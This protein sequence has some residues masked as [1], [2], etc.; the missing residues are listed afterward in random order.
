MQVKKILSNSVYNLIGQG[1]PIL[2]AVYTLPILISSMGHERLGILFIIWLFIG[3]FSIFDFG[4]GRAL[5]KLIAEKN[6]KNEQD[7]VPGLIFTSL[8]LMLG[9]GLFGGLLLIILSFFLPSMVLKVPENLRQETEHSL[10][11]VGLCIPFITM[12]AG[13]K[14]VLEANHK[15]LGLNVIRFILGVTT[16]LL[17]LFLYYKYESITV[18]VVGLVLARILSWLGQAFLCNRLYPLAFK[19]I[20][21]Q[22]KY[23]KELISFGGWMTAANLFAPIL[24]YTDK[25]FLGSIISVASVTYYSVPYDM[26]TKLLIIP[27]AL[28]ATLLP[29]FTNLIT[30]SKR[31]A[32]LQ[33]SKIIIYTAIV[34]FPICFTLIVFSKEILMYWIDEDFSKHSAMVFQIIILAIFINSLTQI[35][36]VYMQAKGRVD[37]TAKILFVEILIYIPVLVFLTKSYGVIGTAVSFLFRVALDMILFYSALIY[38]DNTVNIRKNVIYIS[39]LFSFLTL[40]LVF[41]GNSHEYIYAMAVF[42]LYISFFHENLFSL[43]K[44]IK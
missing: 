26:G 11:I 44:A 9:L 17:P 35:V 20:K 19:N 25:F 29:L 28:L 27:G 3:Y 23:N 10:F 43:F 34:M 30:S 15:F 7:D 21:Y 37:V 31:E 13:F 2:V 14:G 16:Y 41:E 33:L 32:N 36:F 22:K 24:I 38:N 39:I 8:T 42:V 4:L 1:A 40:P 5:T 18:I 12:S 6:T